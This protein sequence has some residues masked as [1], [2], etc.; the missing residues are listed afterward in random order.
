MSQSSTA[1]C[2]VVCQVVKSR[3]SPISRGQDIRLI[4]SSPPPTPCLLQGVAKHEDRRVFLPDRAA[5]SLKKACSSLLRT[6][7]G[8]S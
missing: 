7:P 2:P 8:F 4:V 6:I 3:K 5:L 1:S